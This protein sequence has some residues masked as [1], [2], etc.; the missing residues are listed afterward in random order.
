MTLD[1]ARAEIHRCMVEHDAVPYTDTG[2]GWETCRHKMFLTGMLEDRKGGPWVQCNGIY[3]EYKRGTQ[4]WRS[5]RWAR[6]D[7][8]IWGEEYT[9]EQ[10][11][12]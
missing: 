1:E 7:E 8:I 2:S 10:S 6:M 5:R 9:E 11:T 4:W 3:V 12:L